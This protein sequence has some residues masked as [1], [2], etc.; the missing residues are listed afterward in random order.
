[1]KT[2]SVSYCQ[3]C[4][5]DFKNNEIVYFI[6]IDNNIVCGECAEKADTINIQTRIYEQ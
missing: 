6:E 3:S 1:M 2:T 5:R 4:Q